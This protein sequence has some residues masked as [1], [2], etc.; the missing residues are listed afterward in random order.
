MADM[1]CLG[2]SFV[3]GTEG[4]EREWCLGWEFPLRGVLDEMPWISNST[5]VA[6]RV[7]SI[8]DDWRGSLMMLDDWRWHVC[9]QTLC[10]HCHDWGRSL[11]EGTSL[12][13]FEQRI[14]LARMHMVHWWQ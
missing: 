2:L 10:V 12:N 11:M 6:D 3:C 8:L 14:D 4:L 9:R 13:L 7:S 1:V 5:D